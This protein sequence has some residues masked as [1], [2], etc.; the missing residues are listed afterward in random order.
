MHRFF[1]ISGLVLVQLTSP[2]AVHAAQS[3]SSAQTAPAKLSQ[4]ELEKLVQPIALYPDLLLQQVLAASTF[5]DQV[6]DA[7]MYNE[8]GKDPQG[9]KDQPWDDSVKGIAN[10]PSILVKLASDI[11]WTVALG[12]A[13]I[14]QNEALRKAIQTM[15]ARAKAAGNL[16]DS[17]QQ[18]VIEEKGSD[19]TTII[20]IE[21]AEPQVVY[22]PSTTSATVY[23]Q[24]VQNT[25]TWLVPL[26][27]LGV[28]MALGYALGD[29]HD[30]H[31][32]YG[33]GF[34]GPGFW[35]GGPAVNNWIDY[36]R[37]RWNDAYDYAQDR[38][39]W[40]QHN[41]D[42]WREHRQNLD[43]KQ[44]EWRHQRQVNGTTWTPEKRAEAQSRIN[45][46]RSSRQEKTPDQQRA[47]LQNRNVQRPTLSQRPT[48][49]N[50]DR[51]IANQRL[52]QAR[53]NP[54]FQQRSS[55]L[56][57]EP[58]VQQRAQQRAQ[59]AA[60]RPQQ[61]PSAS[62]VPP[63]SGLSGMNR[64]FDSVNRSAAR[65]TASR[66]SA[67]GFSRGGFGGGRRR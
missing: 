32:Y 66:G 50:V 48:G 60:P 67:G 55:Q 53:N 5:P 63:G 57:L 59:P 49:S 11:D 6:L 46:T 18:H 36:R 38:E 47:D 20:R 17:Q 16:K 39:D 4:R 19:N 56:G 3:T 28:G 10:Y 33:G 25:S 2:P 24:P 43:H 1:L 61:R 51:E 64:S 31:Y 13:F 42:D 45:N 37:D 35:Y 58:P 14:N 41:R 62:T 12:S 8:Q 9:I 23:E 22:V 21:P 40:R 34:Y 44:Q 15:R 65:G 54:Q 27:S 30:D 29:S 52:N 26:A 7:A